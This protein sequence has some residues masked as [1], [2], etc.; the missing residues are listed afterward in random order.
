[1]L[2]EH[3]ESQPDCGSVLARMTASNILTVENPGGKSVGLQRILNLTTWGW[4]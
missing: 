2:M 4:L 3:S 1:M